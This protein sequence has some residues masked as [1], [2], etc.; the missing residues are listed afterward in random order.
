MINL[1]ITVIILCVVGGLVYWLVSML[2]LPDPFPVVIRVCVILIMLLLFLG[3]LFGGVD[4]PQLRR[5]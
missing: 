1:L 3:V 4:L 2:P 5:F